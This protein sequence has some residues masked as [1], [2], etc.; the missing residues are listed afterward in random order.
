[1]ISLGG[2]WQCPK[3]TGG[4]QVQNKRKQSLPREFLPI[5]HFCEESSLSWEIWL[6]KSRKQMFESF[7]WPSQSP[8]LLW[9]GG[10]FYCVQGDLL[11]RATNPPALVLQLPGLFGTAKGSFETFHCSLSD[12]GRPEQGWFPFYV[13]LLVHCRAH[14]SYKADLQIPVKQGFPTTTTHTK[15]S[16]WGGKCDGKERGVSILIA[17]TDRQMQEMGVGQ[18]LQ[19]MSW[20]TQCLG[21]GLESL[22]LLCF[23]WEDWPLFSL[24]QSI[25]VF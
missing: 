9:R 10:C 4:L 6:A 20:Q 21:K 14:F 11:W 24:P 2:W 16:P 15:P 25:F 7:L 5:K 22:V 17:S 12:Q 13:L 23:K 18:H 3:Q 8:R 19:E 1:M